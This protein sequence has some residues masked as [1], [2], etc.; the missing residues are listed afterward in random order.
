MIQITKHNVGAIAER[1]VANE[2]EARGFCVSHLNKDNSNAPN[3]DLLA[4]T[5]Q[6]TI[7]VQ[8]KG[9]VNKSSDPWWV[10]Y[11]YCTPTII[12]NRDE[13][14]FN[15]RTE[16]LQGH[17][18]CIGRGSIPERLFVYRASCGGR[19]GRGAT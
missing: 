18:R 1:I 12:A 9:A 2:L 10:G 7:Q 13:P 6:S 19:A 3:A 8:V 11:G 16:L 14:M 17:S 15:R 4:V 5:P